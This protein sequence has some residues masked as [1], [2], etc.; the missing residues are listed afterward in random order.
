MK[1][2][3][4]PAKLLLDVSEVSA[5]LGL[6]RSKI[7]SYI[8]SGQLRSVLCGRRRKIPSDALPEFIQSLEQSAGSVSG[9]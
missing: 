2:L 6:G 3:N 4:P 8:L 1:E 9:W 7:Y 5:L